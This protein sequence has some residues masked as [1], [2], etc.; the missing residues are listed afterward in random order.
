MRYGSQRRG[1]CVFAPPEEVVKSRFAYSISAFD[2]VVRT[3]ILHSILNYIIELD[4]TQLL[5]LLPVVCLRL[6]SRV[7]DGVDATA[8][9]AEMILFQTKATTNPP[10]IWGDLNLSGV[11]ILYLC[12]K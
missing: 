9:T 5:S 12:R 4:S 10:V 1:S 2:K 7:A 6:H 3:D 11:H 8:T